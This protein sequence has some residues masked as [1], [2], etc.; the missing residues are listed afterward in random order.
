MQIVFIING[1]DVPIDCTPWTSLATARAWAMEESY[2]T[3][4]PAEEWELR[5]ERGY[6]LDPALKVGACG[7]RD[8]ERIFLTLAAGIGGD[9]AQASGW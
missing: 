6:R 1:E 2:N 3:G 7:F 8:R 9:F 4:R 5:N